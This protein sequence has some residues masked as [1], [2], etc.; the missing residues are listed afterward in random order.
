M[1]NPVKLTTLLSLLALTGCVELD[2]SMEEASFAEAE[3]ELAIPTCA[4]GTWCIEPSPAGTATVHDVWA[5]GA[6]D[7]FAVGDGG[8]IMRRQNSEWIAMAS[9]TTLSLRAV[10]GTSASNVWAVGHGGT[11]LRFDGTAWSPVAVTTSNIDAIW[12][13]DANTI[14]MSG[15]STVWRSA[16]GGASFTASN[17]TGSLF[18]ISGTS[19]SEVYVT[20]ENSYVRK[21]SGSTWSTINPGAGTT[22]YFSVLAIAPGDVW[23]SDYTPSKETMHLVKGKW[24]AK[25]T[26][27]AV[28]QDL[29]ATTANDLWGVGGSKVGRFNGS[30]WTVT[31]PFGT[32]S[33]WSV[34]GAPGHVWAVGGNGLVAH[35]AY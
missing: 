32:T 29:H 7:V 30:A 26:S 31:A 15:G 8:L 13:A 4:S 21:W 27:S 9:G 1:H 3:S 24:V 2:D 12:L 18:A 22:T 14:F 11:V 5:A 33:L 23:V 6:N 17:M 35:Y 34:S 10:F 16:N 28:F 19:A 20:G 25:A